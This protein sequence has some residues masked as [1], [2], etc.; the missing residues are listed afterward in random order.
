VE[1]KT[2][3][4]QEETELALG[5][6]RLWAVTSD[7]NWKCNCNS[8]ANKSNQPIQNPLLLVTRNLYTWQNESTP[9]TSLFLRRDDAVCVKATEK[10]LN[11]AFFVPL[12]YFDGCETLLHSLDNSYRDGWEMPPNDGRY[13]TITRL[14]M[15]VYLH[16]C[17]MHNLRYLQSCLLGQRMEL[18]PKIFAT[19]IF[20]RIYGRQTREKGNVPGARK[21]NVMCSIPLL[22][23][24]GS[25]MQ[26]MAPFLTL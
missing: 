15:V 21:F 25:A 23:S 16:R 4:V 6:H 12:E 22:S 5:S 9:L 24:A 7:C 3:V 8:S 26:F 17:I 2:L 13:S 1:D 10:E 18:S 11:V 20:N 19:I 14:Q